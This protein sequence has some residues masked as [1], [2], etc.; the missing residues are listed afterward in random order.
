LRRIIPLVTALVLIPALAAPAATL[1]EL[2]ERGRQAAYSGEQ[3]IS[4]ETPDG[5]R[6][7]I[8]QIRQSGGVVSV[9]SPLAGGEVASGSGTWALTRDGGVIDEA[10]LPGSTTEVESDYEV[11][12]LGPQWF[13]GR[14]ATGY[15]LVRDGEVRADIVIDDET[16]AM[17]RVASLD[18]SGNQ[19]CVRRFISFDSSDPALESPS[20]TDFDGMTLVE[21][22]VAD[23]P[24]TVAGFT[25]LDRYTDS[26]GVKLA[27]YSD[28]FFSF[29]LFEAPQR[30]ELSGGV[31]HL[32]GEYRYLRDY[33]A[34][35][36]TYV[37]QVR[38]VGFALV[39]D[40][41]PD[42]HPEVLAAFP[43]PAELGFFHRMWRNL[44]GVR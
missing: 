5:Y 37:W 18:D 39:G 6:G 29:A 11:E 9:S 10:R 27:Y 3:M 20:E 34:G 2:L 22:E 33:A 38:G 36:V 32:D 16:G 13:L 1:E 35:Q 43:R 17:V 15:R 21:G 40:L 7:V 14:D 8:A 23:L 12:D 19:Y 24:L 26:R 4:C 30:V 41:P 28:G 44:F 31:E 42:L 25:L